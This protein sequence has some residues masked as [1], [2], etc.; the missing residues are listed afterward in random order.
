[1]LSCRVI[2]LGLFSHPWQIK[3]C[4]PSTVIRSCA[5][6]PLTKCPRSIWWLSSQY[7]P[8]AYV[9]KLVK[10][11]VLLL[12]AALSLRICSLMYIYF[13]AM[14]SQAVS[15]SCF[16]ELPSSLKLALF[17]G[18]YFSQINFLI[19]FIA[20]SYKFLHQQKQGRKK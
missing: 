3:F 2:L 17:D 6:K 18:L 8:M 13:G 15:G 9:D 12:A 4:C 20:C 14:L 10:S 16:P 1:M 19:Q 11:M 5:V 7:T